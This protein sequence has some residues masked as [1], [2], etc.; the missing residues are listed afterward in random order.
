MSRVP[1][2]ARLNAGKPIA[3][4]GRREGRPAP[5]PHTIR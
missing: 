4:E 5:G 3:R 1:S 2:L